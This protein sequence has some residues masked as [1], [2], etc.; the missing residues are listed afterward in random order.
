MP[1]RTVRKR[2]AQP[3]RNAV[4]SRGNGDQV[5]SLI[6]ALG[7]LNRIAEAPDGASLTD[8]AQQV[9]LPTSTAHRLL[10][11][12]EQE[13]YVRFNHEQRLWT[14][15][16]QAFVTG[17]TFTKTRSL[18]AVARPHMRHLMEEGGE[19]VN[20]AIVDEGQAV[21]LA[22][23]ECSQMMRVFARP[24]TRVPLHCSGV[25][26]AILSATSDKSL[27]RILHQHGMPRLTVKTITAPL[28]LREELERVRAVGY[29]V[30]DEEHAVGLRCIAAPIFDE[31]GDVVAAVSASGPMAR[32]VEERIAP[33]G[34]L[35]LDAARA[36]SAD[37]GATLR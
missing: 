3:G 36:I 9:G 2:A 18:V 19:T 7:L 35:V 8:L 21:Y 10:T 34:G 11:T 4:A 17:C 15:G 28:P 25:G 32:I 24:G 20:L 14:V 1:Q 13:R 12:L 37:M 33:L 30:D 6:R 31:T 23:I 26:K 22:Q 27:S 5:Q 29:A 16:V